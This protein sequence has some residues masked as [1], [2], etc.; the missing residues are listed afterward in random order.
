MLLWLGFPALALPLSFELGALSPS[1]W[2]DPCGLSSSSLGRWVDM[3]VVVGGH[4]VRVTCHAL[5][6]S[7]V[8]KECVA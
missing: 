3:V 1:L 5:D 4:L 2:G 6:F 8:I 7:G